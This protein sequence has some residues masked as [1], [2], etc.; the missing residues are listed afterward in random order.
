[1]IRRVEPDGTIGTNGSNARH[2]DSGVRYRVANSESVSFDYVGKMRLRRRDVL[3]LRLPDKISESE[4]G[5]LAKLLGERFP[6]N[7]CL[8]LAPGTSLEVYRS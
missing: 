8:V 7:R 2:S 4:A 1:V 3:V 6:R 5:S